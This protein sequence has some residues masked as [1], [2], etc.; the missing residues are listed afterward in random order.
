MVAE[1]REWE[2]WNQILINDFHPS[3]V[4]CRAR[5]W[6]DAG[7]RTIPENS[8]EGLSLENAADHITIV[9]QHIEQSGQLPWEHGVTEARQA[10]AAQRLCFAAARI[11]LCMT[12][13]RSLLGVRSLGPSGQEAW[14]LLEEAFTWYV[15]GEQAGSGR[16]HPGLHEAMLA[17]AIPRILA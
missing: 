14:G 9:A 2:P 10:G 8:Q 5:A 4:A 15:L 12:S 1:Y 11:L 7:G 16:N 13:H 6:L 3:F 17:F